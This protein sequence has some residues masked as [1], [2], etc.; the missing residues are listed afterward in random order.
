MGLGQLNDSTCANKLHTLHALLCLGYFGFYS[1]NGNSFTPTGD[2][3]TNI[4]DEV[5]DIVLSEGRGLLYVSG[6][7]F[8][9][10]IS[11]IPCNNLLIFIVSDS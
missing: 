11:S 8:L 4:P 10:T 3:T 1:F 2:I 9:S 6:K 7:G 5:F